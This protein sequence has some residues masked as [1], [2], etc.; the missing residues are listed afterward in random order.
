MEETAYARMASNEAAHWWFVGRR[1]ILDALIR[2]VLAPIPEP[3]RRILE[4][5]CGSGGNLGL[6][7]RF[8]RV[9]AVEHDARARDLAR[10]RTGIAVR[11]ATLPGHLPA[12]DGAFALVT[13][14][15]VLEHVEAERA[16]LQAIGR[17]LGPDGRLLVT[18]PAM[19]WLWSSHD[20]AHHHKRRYTRASLTA[21]LASAGLDVERSGYF[22]ALLF[23]LAVVRRLMDRLPGRAA[24]D[25]AIPPRPVN[26][27]LRAVLASERH[28]ILRTRLPVGLSVFAVAR[29]SDGRRADRPEARDGS[30][31]AVERIG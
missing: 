31:P 18:V 25:D 19:P 28:L 15:D 26:A 10:A 23:P 22:N 8:G 5:G 7:A 12:E 1:A 16:A 13:L 30:V 27:I 11:P 3:G 6:L 21:A 29:R 24:A 20:V 14:L 9:E 4:V 17:K 2:D